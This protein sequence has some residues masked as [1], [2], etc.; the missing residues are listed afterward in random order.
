MSIP[1]KILSIRRAKARPIIMLGAVQVNY[2]GIGIKFHHA[3]INEA[4]SMA[5]VRLRIARA[6]IKKEPRH[7]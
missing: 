2:T 5:I 7:D 4:A 1:F 6:R 3:V